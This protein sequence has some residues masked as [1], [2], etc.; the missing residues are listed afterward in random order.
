MKKKPESAPIV[1]R[2]A[3]F[4]YELGET[5]SAGII[6]SGAEVRGTRMGHV[7]LTGSYANIKQNELWLTN[8]SISIP[9]TARNK[10]DDKENSNPRKLLVTKKELFKIEEAKKQGMTIVPTR[11]FTTGRFI[12]IELSLAKGKK[13]YDKRETIKRRQQ[14]RDAKREIKR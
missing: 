13:N 5:I 7:R 2:R 6:L 14:D 12:K 1:N 3:R 9:D 10:D 8:M 11:L 4:D